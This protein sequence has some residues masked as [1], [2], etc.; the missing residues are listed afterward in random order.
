MQMGENRSANIF[1][2]YLD[3]SDM[4]LALRSTQVPNVDALLLRWLAALLVATW[5]GRMSH[6]IE[7]RLYKVSD[8]RACIE[9]RPDY[10]KVGGEQG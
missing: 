7:P 9:N 2:F 1:N 3:L 5:L 4:S 8:D 6:R 10:G